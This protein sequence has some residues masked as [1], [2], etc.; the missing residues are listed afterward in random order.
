MLQNLYSLI[1]VTFLAIGSQVRAELPD[2][3]TAVGIV[4]KF[5]KESVT[6][7]LADNRQKSL[8]KGQTIAVIYAE[9]DKEYVLLNAV[10]K[11]VEKPGELGENE[12]LEIAKAQVGKND[13]WADRAEYTLTKAKDGWEVEVWRIPNVPGCVRYI[14]IDQKGNVLK[15]VRGK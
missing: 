11:P 1:V 15:Y 9:A 12:I 8:A 2:F 5:D 13:D 3:V 10:M 4:D 14:S 7:T 6:I